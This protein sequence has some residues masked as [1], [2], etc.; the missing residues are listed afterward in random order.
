MLVRFVLDER[1]TLRI[2]A[3]GAPVSAGELLLTKKRPI[4]QDHSELRA[5][6]RLTITRRGVL[7]AEDDASALTTLDERFP[8]LIEDMSHGGFLLMCTER[9]SVGQVLNFSCELLPEQMLEC[10]IKVM[11][12]GDSIMGVKIVDIDDKGI[13]LCQLFLRD[14][15]SMQHLKDS[16]E[17]VKSGSTRQRKSNS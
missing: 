2:S 4:K 14:Q 5:F 7:T 13:E 15:F 11:H 9:F 12:V 16:I 1:L 8:C 6:S 3:L 17:S 10:K